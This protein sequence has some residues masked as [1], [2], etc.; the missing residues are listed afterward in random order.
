MDFQIKTE[1]NIIRFAS[2][3]NFIIACEL[4]VTAVWVTFAISRVSVPR[5]RLSFTPLMSPS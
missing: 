5:I 3:S 4:P 2:I 1:T